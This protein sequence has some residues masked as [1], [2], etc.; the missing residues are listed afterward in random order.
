MGNYQTVDVM[1]E[2]LGWRPRIIDIG[3]PKKMTR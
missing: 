3:P 1:T 2:K